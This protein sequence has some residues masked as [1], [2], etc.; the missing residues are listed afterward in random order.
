MVWASVLDAP[1]IGRHDDFFALGGHSLSA[2]RVAARLRQSLGL[3]LPLHTLF[4]QRTVAALAIAVETVLLAE[5]EA[6]PA[7]FPATA[8]AA[9][10]SLVLQGETS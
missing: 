3:D 7:P 10:P 1:R 2:T 5:L 4:E 8:D 6:E 9:V